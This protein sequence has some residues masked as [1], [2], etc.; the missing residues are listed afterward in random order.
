MEPVDV[1]S[2]ASPACRS[3][4]RAGPLLSA[5]GRMLRGD[6]P[7]LSIEI[8]RDCPLRCPG[9]Y[10]Y[11]ADHL[12]GTVALRQLTDLRGDALVEGVLKLV[13]KH[14]PVQVSF[15]GGEP[16]LRWKE[17]SRILPVLDRWGVDSLVV[18][19]AVISFPNEWDKIRRVRVAV[20]VDGLQPEHDARRAPATYA[21]ILKN[22]QGRN[23]DVSWVVTDP[24][25]Q[26]KGY[27]DDYL[28]FWT[29]RPE[30]HRIWLSLY[31]PQKGE[32][33]LER[34]TSESR[35]RLIEELPRLKRK[36]HR[37]ILASGTAD[38]FARPPADPAH[39]TFARISTNYSA[40]L[41][42]IVKPCFFGGQPDCS[43]CGCAISVGLHKIHETPLAPG[44]KAGRVIDLS[45]ACGD[46]WKAVRRQGHEALAK[47]KVFPK[48][49]TSGTER[50]ASSRAANV[51]PTP[52][53]SHTRVRRNSFGPLREE[54]GSANSDFRIDGMANQES[55]LIPQ[56]GHTPSRSSEELRQ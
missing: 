56:L 45:L 51:E 23:V 12:G 22:I 9:C 7:L 25:L 24:M 39:C 40:D 27:L 52:P 31:T 46:F 50:T 4:L 48:S 8:T 55:H 29:A 33:S 42:T 6:S 34:L 54:E 30:I 38:A 19:S 20:S 41:K 16:L 36:Y 10:A 14:R 13:R 47:F 26:R 43:V 17:L 1:T 53:A 37:L 3:P 35:N 32:Q 28:A 21:R 49:S 5:W 44:L 18:T 11:G 15:V 2:N